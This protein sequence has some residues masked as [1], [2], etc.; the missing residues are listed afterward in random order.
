MKS[1]KIL[2]WN[3][4]VKICRRKWSKRAETSSNAK[5]FACRTIYLIYRPTHANVPFSCC[6]I[7][8]RDLSA[9]QFP[10]KDANSRSRS[11]YQYISGCSL[12]PGGIQ[13]F[14]ICCDSTRINSAGKYLNFG[15]LREVDVRRIAQP[16]AN[17][18]LVPAPE[19]S[20][21]SH[22]VEQLCVDENERK[23]QRIREERSPTEHFRR[24]SDIIHDVIEVDERRAKKRTSNVGKLR[25]INFK[26]QRKETSFRL[27]FCSAEIMQSKRKKIKE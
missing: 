17:D 1:S 15:R 2:K 6:A 5:Q 20:D 4:G 26:S 10:A 18:S 24:C 8:G 14:G 3:A 12:L 13:S 23:S 27:G 7:S 9:N 25:G 16:G 21:S 22:L 11:F 19:V